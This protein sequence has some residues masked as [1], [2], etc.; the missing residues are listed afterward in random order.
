M[1]T[2][3]FLLA[4]H[5]TLAT[6]RTLAQPLPLTPIRA[7]G[8]SVTAVFEGWYKNADGTFS[9]SFGYFNRNAE[10]TVEITMG[11]NNFIAP[12]TFNGAQPTR[13][14]PRRHWGVFVVTV[15][16]NFGEQRVVWT[17]INRGDTVAIPGSLRRN[18]EID[19]L[20]GEAGSGN[21]P[22]LVSFAQG[23]PASSGP[24]GVGTSLTGKVGESLTLTLWASD[25]GRARTSVASDGR[26]G[27]WP[28]LTWFVHQAPA[29]SRVEFGNPSPGVGGDGKATTSVTFSAPGAY[30]LRARVND[31]SG[32]SSAGHAQC[33]WTNAFVTVTVS[34]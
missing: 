33:C 7:S 2:F 22:P 18:W 23:G 9:L 15:P 27:V 12:S 19:A 13:F 26:R 8:Q 16:A 10:E 17:L 5:L 1:R 20:A 30:V 31:A 24:R 28:S 11:P 34:H 4:L 32:V 3:R 21:T 29:G 14:A 25:D 6:V